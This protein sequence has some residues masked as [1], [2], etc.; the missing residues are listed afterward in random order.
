MLLRLL[1]V[2]YKLV[3]SDEFDG[4]EIDG[5]KWDFYM[6]KHGSEE[7]YYT[8]RREN[9]IIR[10]GKLVIIARKEAYEDCGYTS[11]SLFTRYKDGYPGG[12]TYGKVQVR[13]KIPS[14]MGQ[15]PA[16]WMM[17]TD[18]K[19]GWWPKSG[20][21]D[22]MEAVGQNPN[23]I[24]GTIHCEKYN[25]L[26]NTAK[27]GKIRSET[28]YS[29]FH[30]YEMIWDGDGITFLLD[31]YAYYTYVPESRDHTVWPFDERFYLK[32]NL[33]IGGWGGAPD[34]RL[35]PTE[36]QIEYVRVYAQI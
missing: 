11:A 24:Y 14:G 20:E 3:W 7:Q 26:N 8:D 36:Y 18:N 30:D 27:G 23:I 1:I 6:G 17:P 32:L 22:I 29:D 9:S 28:V 12:W 25:H 15:W 2:D 19:F 13:A 16:I 31:D 10:D 4:N 33:A 21:I 35:F 34:D 5:E